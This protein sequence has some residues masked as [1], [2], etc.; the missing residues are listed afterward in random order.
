MAA[1]QGGSGGLRAWLA[2]QQSWGASLAL[3]LLRLTVG[4]GLLLPGAEKLMKLNGGCLEDPAPRCEADAKAGCAADQACLDLSHA[5]CKDERVVACKEAAAASE[6][7][8]SGLRLFDRDDLALPGGGRINM[9][10]AGVVE[11]FG[12]VALILGLL[13]RLWSIP[14]AFTMF[15]AMA[16]AHADRFTP[17]L[18]FVH[19]TAWL[20]LVML[21]LILAMG[22]GRLAVDA[23]FAARTAGKSAGSGGK[24]SGKSGG[25]ASGNDGGK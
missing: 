19:E 12:G 10:A 13:A 24:S 1:R 21:A 5:R 2:P 7:F 16:A 14:A 17:K 6:R 11:L 25:K 18:E 20:Y 23:W 3:L 9:L 4:W 15:V 22:P 8:F